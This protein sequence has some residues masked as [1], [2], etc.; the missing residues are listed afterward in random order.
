[1]LREENKIIIE[2]TQETKLT[3][4]DAYSGGGGEFRKVDT[5]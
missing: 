3:I 2:N 4:I 5:Q 1:M